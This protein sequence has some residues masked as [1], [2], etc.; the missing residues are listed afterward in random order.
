MSS[1]I[2]TKN[3]ALLIE[4]K[5]EEYFF[6]APFEHLS[7]DDVQ[8]VQYEGKNNLSAYLGAFMLFR[9][10]EQLSAFGILRDADDDASGAFNSVVTSLQKA[11]LPHPKKSGDCANKGGKK[12]GIFI[13]PGNSASGM[14]E[15]LCLS[16]VEGH[17]IMPFVRT[18][19]SSLEGALTKRLPPNAPMVAGVNYFPKNEPK[20]RAQA[21]LSGMH[22]TF[23]SVGLAA[24]RRYWDFDHRILDDLKEFFR[25]LR[26]PV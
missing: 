18:F 25:K 7:I 16:T 22:E 24:K 5:D 21:F 9:G 11:N 19:F 15:N 13:L 20:A 14:L 1:G 10:Y 6:N 23:G 3:K 12:V 8:I 26:T 2:L 17:P 4:G